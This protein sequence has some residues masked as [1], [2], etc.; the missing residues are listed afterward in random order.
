MNSCE[1]FSFNRFKLNEYE[2]KLCKIPPMNKQSIKIVDAWELLMSCPG[3]CLLLGNSH[4]K[5][6]LLNQLFILA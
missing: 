6:A 4:G 5:I 3:W 2:M 1:S